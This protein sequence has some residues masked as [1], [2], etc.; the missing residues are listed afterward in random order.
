MSYACHGMPEH[1]DGIMKILFVIFIIAIVVAGTLCLLEQRD[2]LESKPKC[3][4]CNSR[5][6]N[7]LRDTWT[8][9]LHFSQ[10]QKQ[11]IDD[12]GYE[13]VYGGRKCYQTDKALSDRIYEI[14]KGRKAEWQRNR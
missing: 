12:L 7:Q 14:I 8:C 3:Y 5:A 2:K 10:A 13:F 1:K 9:D 6:R 11:A 4:I